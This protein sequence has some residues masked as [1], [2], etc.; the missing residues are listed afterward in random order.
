M[1]QSRRDLMLALAAA[2]AVPATVAQAK[3]GTRP[4][5]PTGAPHAGLSKLYDDIAADLMHALP[6][7][8]TLMGLDQ[9]RFGEAKHRL[10]DRSA[11]ERAR[12]TSASAAYRKR[13]HAVDRKS[14]KGVQLAVYDTLDYWLAENVAQARFPYWDQMAGQVSPYVV[15][16]ITGAYQSVPDFLD[17]YHTIANKADAD[18][19]MLRLKAFAN[20]LD[21]ETAR[22]KR[23]TGAGVVAPDFI[24]DK[25][26][27][28]ISALRAAP[29]DK[30]TLVTSVARRAKEAHVAGDYE[31]MARRV[32]ES[33]IHPALDRQIEALKA[34][35]AGAGSDPAARRL[36]DGE[37]FY[38]EAL[39]QNI[40]TDLSPAEIHRMGEEVARQLV[41]EIDRS[42][43]AQ[44]LTQ[45]SVGERFKALYA[46]PK[47]RYPDT[48]EGKAKLLA[49]LHAQ[50][51]RVRALLPKA[52][53]TLPRSEM[54]IK[55]VPAYL[56]AG[57]PGAYAWPPGVGGSRPGAYYINLR[58]TAEVPSWTLPTLTHHEGIPGH[59]LQGALE[60]ENPELPL[61]QQILGVDYNLPSF[62]AYL[63]G[64]ALYAEQ[65][66][67]ELGIYE[68]DPMGRIGYLHDALFR[69]GRM[70]ADTGLHAMGWS[71]DKASRYF[72]DL[73]GNPESSA[74][75]EIDRYC[76]W[77]GQACSYMVGKLGWLR[78]REK[79]KAALGPKFDVR[80]FH[81]V[82]LR[83]GAMP[84]AVLEQ[85]VD[86]YVAGV[87]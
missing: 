45:G 67:D 46:D 63:E 56:E 38:L 58:D 31:G 25:A 65:V 6:E 84:M 29:A 62:N 40:T 8:A 23:D 33:E 75:G 42:M 35:R 4:P 9:G 83:A 53:R 82:G 51:D 70:V 61:A 59:Y 27:K 43:K 71:R 48:E 3:P 34:A 69:A 68:N 74:T 30:T 13:L 2:A 14:V 26:L 80:D 36:P 55:R 87:K 5:H 7:T 37:A 16:Q 66:A 47:Y 12:F 77:P 21:Q 22:L 20:C 73:L 79:A 15:S 50:V 28:Q 41:D 11:A 72:Q 81:D 52:F 78:L 57:A 19:Y 76:V 54:V 17:S 10:N 32:L 18:A 24:L 85:V 44:G 1:A 49:D 39:R 86:R 60:N 64:W